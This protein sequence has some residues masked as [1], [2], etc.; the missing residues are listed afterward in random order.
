[1]ADETKE[2]KR[3]RTRE[4]VEKQKN[5][6]NENT[7][8]TSENTDI[9]NKS[10]NH[11]NG[12]SK[13][14]E[15][16]E[17]ANSKKSSR[18]SKNA[19]KQQKKSESSSS[20][21]K[22]KNTSEK[23][24][25]DDDEDD[26]NDLQE[27]V[28]QAHKA[29]KTAQSAY[30][31]FNFMQLMFWLK[32]MFLAAIE[33]LIRAAKWLAQVLTY[34]IHGFLG[35]LFGVSMTGV[36]S[37]IFGT[38]TVLAG[39]AT[40]G[41]WILAGGIVVGGISAIWYL[42]T[43]SESANNV[44]YKDAPVVVE[45]ED[46]VLKSNVKFETSKTLNA[47]YKEIET[48]NANKIYSILY[49]AGF[50]ETNIAGIL[51]NWVHESGGFG[52]GL[53]PTAFL[54]VYS[55]PYHIGPKKQEKIDGGYQDTAIGL[56]QWRGGRKN[57]LIKYGEDHNENGVW[58]EIETEVQFALTADGGDTDLLNGWKKEESDPETAALWFG[59]NWE[60]AGS[61]DYSPR[62]KSAAEFYSRMQNGTIVLDQDYGKSILES[63]SYTEKAA[64]DS[65]TADETHTCDKLD[66]LT[67]A[68]DNSSIASAAVS[69]CRSYTEF[70]SG[71]VRS[72]SDWGTKLYQEIN[73]SIHPGE[74]A[75]T[76]YRD[77]GKY[78]SSVIKWCGADKDYTTGNTGCQYTYLCSSEKWQE[79]DWNGDYTKLLPG[80]VLIT[81]GTGHVCIYAG[82]DAIAAVFPDT[83][84]DKDVVICSASKDGSSAGYPPCCRNFYSDLGRFSAFRCIKPD[85]DTTYKDIGTNLAVQEAIATPAPAPAPS[86]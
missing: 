79:I 85:N 69:L 18:N 43:G 55:E 2:P 73:D 78:V 45:C 4:E 46:G 14:K 36:A 38:G 77:C 59:K 20:E 49:A 62:A 64:T 17:T 61:I 67:A 6:K 56:G 21:L 68:A 41:G 86:K 32:R 84:K 27:K 26:N 83:P 19:S 8:K 23:D 16:E 82:Y 50:P 76:K 72:T 34:A 75:Y 29:A 52:A 15:N 47:G 3:V 71:S 13:K 44:A 5:E 81:Q 24:K 9:T 12:F 63:A 42:A 51:G 11:E 74:K 37:S 80:D 65:A 39:M 66:K 25:E 30:K 53:D 35:G 60:R 22:E 28:K 10:V 33:A 58:Y 7:T 57:N 31:I 54:G 48:E 1:M 40:I 70:S